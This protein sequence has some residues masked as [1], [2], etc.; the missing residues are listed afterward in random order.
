MSIR[1][2]RNSN[3]RKSA[4]RLFGDVRLSLVSAVL[5]LLN[6]AMF[7]APFFGYAAENVE[8]GFNGG[9]IM[10]SLVLLMLLLNYLAFYLILYL[11]RIVG[12]ILLSFLFIGSSIGY[13]FI[14]TYDV[15]IDDTMMGNVFNT[16]YSE[17]SAYYSASALLYVLFM[18]ILPS[19]LL[20][21][22]KIDYGRLKGFFKNIGYTLVV[23]IVIAFVNITNWPWIDRHSTVG[24]SLVLPWSYVINSFRYQNSV[25]EANR[26]E[27]I[28]PDATIT[29]DV[30][31][32][33]VL[34]IGESARRDHFS[35]YGY[36]R[37]TNPR[38]SRIDG[39]KAYKAN[40]SATYTTAGVKAILEYR[41]CGELYEILPNYLFRNGVDVVWRSSNWGQPPLHIDRYQ[42]STDVAAQYEGVSDSLDESLIAGLRNLVETSQKNK[43][44][45][46]LHTSTSHGPAYTTRYPPEF[47]LFKPVCNTV[48][49]SKCPHDQLM[50]AYDNTI[51]YTDYL[52]SEVIGQLQSLTDWKSCMIYVSDHGESLGEKNLYMHGVPMSVAPAEQYEIPFIVWRSDGTDSCRQLDL[53]GQHH[54]FHSVL[55]F[56]G[57]GSPVFD[58]GYCIFD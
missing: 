4:G 47:E 19:V 1:L 33:V 51:V 22:T 8:K 35:L 39:L 6:V 54:V 52:L 29:D 16:N 53:I 11:G 55:R 44:L 32:V 7:H 42:T 45:I 43:M 38:L 26:E 40:S 3:D 12:K 14:R 34:V 13:Y 20:F 37:E 30:K 57:I 2:M 56:L 5:S 36:E 10:V 31:S 24:G 17:A 27:I 15:M 41:D 48:E 50:N 18:G 58:D 21:I 9:L 23:C 28:L 25:R 46:V 49:M